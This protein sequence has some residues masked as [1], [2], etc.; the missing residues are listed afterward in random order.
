VENVRSA[1]AAARSL[2]AARSEPRPRRLTVAP[3]ARAVGGAQAAVAQGIPRQVTAHALRVT[4]AKNSPNPSQPITPTTKACLNVSRAIDL[5]LGPDI[6]VRATALIQGLVNET[7]SFGAGEFTEKYYVV[8]SPPHAI[9][10]PCEGQHAWIR[11]CR[12]GPRSLG[13]YALQAQS[14]IGIGPLIFSVIDPGERSHLILLFDDVDCVKWD[15]CHI[16]FQSLLSWIRLLSIAVV[17]P[18]R[19]VPVVSILVV[20][21]Q[22]SQPCP[23]Q[24]RSRNS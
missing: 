17:S 5:W 7:L 19:I 2:A 15:R 13:V 1:K 20:L 24:S 3:L 21:D 10:T 22:T 11:C 6:D 16:K 8:S 14:G 23:A 18:A 12:K 4:G 9:M